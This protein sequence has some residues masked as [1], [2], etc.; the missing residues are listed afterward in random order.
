M[1]RLFRLWRLTGRDLRILWQAL[2]QPTRPRWL[3]PATIA[4]AIFALEPINFAIPFVGVLDDLVVLPLLLRALAQLALRGLEAAK[5]SRSA[6]DRVV[7]I[8]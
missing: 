1:R 8:Q 2:R 7:S 3:I 5:S 4:L 6:D